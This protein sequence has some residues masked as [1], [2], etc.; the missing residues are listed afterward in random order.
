MSF[1]TALLLIVLGLAIGMTACDLNPAARSPESSLRIGGL[2]CLSEIGPTVSA[3][4]DDEMSEAQI[5]EF[6]T[7]VQKSFTLFGTYTRGSKQGEYTPEE[8]RTFLQK[9]FIK[10]RKISDNLLK[11]F[12]IVKTTLVGGNEQ[13]IN[14][15]DL[16]VAIS[17]LETLKNEALRL[18]P[19][20]RVLNPKLVEKEPKEN[21]AE[22][23]S[24]AHK[25]L[26]ETTEVLV[27]L[28]ASAQQPYSIQNF[29]NLIGELRQFVNWSE[30]FNNAQPIR[31]WM[32]FFR[33]FKNVMVSP[34]DRINA[35][36]WAPL[37]T[38]STNWY[39]LYIEVKSL[40]SISLI[41]EPEQLRQLNTS[42]MKGISYL[43]KMFRKPGEVIEF[44]RF[45]DLYESLE[46][47]GWI[48]DQWPK[49]AVDK[50]FR[51]VVTKVLNQQKLPPEKRKVRGLMWG[52]VSILEQELTQWYRYQ[53][54]IENNFLVDTQY[55]P[56]RPL[57][58]DGVDGIYLGYNINTYL[59]ID[60]FNYT[61]FNAL[62]SISGL[63]IQGYAALPKKGLTRDELQNVYLDI[64]DLMIAWDLAD[65]REEKTGRRAY[66]E[67]NLFTF[68]ANGNDFL[69]QDELMQ[70]I[71]FL[72]SAGQMGTKIYKEI[73]PYCYD[74]GLDIYNENVLLRG[75]TAKYLVEHLGHMMP[76]VPDFNRF[77]NE[78]T[79]EDRQE[80]VSDLLDT[81]YG[82]H[83]QQDVVESS[84]LSTLAA[85]VQYEST[86]F[87]RYNENNDGV[88]TG[89]ELDKAFGTF[90]WLIRSMAQ[91]MCMDLSEKDAR[92]AFN[93][94]LNHYEIPEKNISTQF[95]FWFDPPPSNLD[96]MRLNKVFKALIRKIIDSG[97][98][99]VCGPNPPPAKK[100]AL[101]R[102]IEENP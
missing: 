60:R 51:A 29:Q 41:W 90:G 76:N 91:L 1:R 69:E 86:V 56:E 44:E 73:L 75:C 11:E 33:N 45:S 28:L 67:G 4:I 64:R 59:P 78:M 34:S 65:P 30:H 48:S 31:N 88:L 6:F 57:Y 40:I 97:G 37:L 100:K 58:V 19:Y 84:E 85:I 94:I 9:Y 80:F 71:A 98:Q 43:Y 68:H 32:N 47:M 72:K 83:S 99:P 77:F 62:R 53:N 89:I 93:Y 22:R 27:P 79:Y 50:I 46:K 55:F 49:E 14:R 5:T 74:A 8:I 52:H 70:L 10:D 24:M 82:R 87:I 102:V 3:Y 63:V 42:A 2:N 16:Q 54:Q 36:D 61:V 7:C 23:I 26:R 38:A 13:T 12:M 101:P 21:L 95:S 17:I 92:N 66:L 18:K 39:M 20:L 35:Q 81:S 96:R 15:Q 25:K